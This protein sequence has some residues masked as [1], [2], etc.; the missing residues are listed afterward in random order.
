[1]PIPEKVTFKDFH[2]QRVERSFYLP[3][4]FDHLDPHDP[5]FLYTEIVESLD[6]S[7]IIE[8]HKRKGE[9]AYHPCMLFL[10]ILYGYTH[11]IFSSRK[12]AERCKKDLA[13]MYITG[14]LKPD[15][16]TISDFRKN[17]IGKIK[18]L[19]IQSVLIAKELQM[20]S[21]GHVS[22]D[23][24][25]FE[26][27][28]SKHKA[29]SYG[30]I[31]EK[32]ESLKKEIEALLTAAK[33]MDE[34]EDALHGEEKSGQEIPEELQ[35]KKN[36]LKKIR[37]AKKSLEK[38]EEAENPGKEIDDRKQISF[39]DNDAKIMG[40]GGKDFKYAYNAQVS[41][42]KDSQVIVGA[43]LT[44]K[45]NDMQEVKPALQEIYETTGQLPEKASLDAGYFSSDNL[46]E[47]EANKIDGY[48]A[49]G[50]GE[51][52]GEV[53]EVLP[54]GFTVAEDEE[55]LICRAGKT[56]VKCNEKGE[57]AVKSY[58]ASIEVCRNC[59]LSS[60]CRTSM[61]AKKVTLDKNKIKRE[62]MRIKLKTPEGKEVYAKRKHIVEP[63]F[64][65]IKN[66]M[67]FRR[68]QLRGF[69]KV[70]GE[71]YLICMAHNMKKVINQLMIA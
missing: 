41:V 69:E 56:L 53:K 63:V 9:N 50:K 58:K 23:G 62:E 16:R 36:R 3:S 19:F 49:T 8:T 29:M 38:R 22:L 2:S 33:E 44:Q 12:L 14:L 25:L 64:G 60:E 40:K 1:M 37:N 32:E 55:T 5:V 52:A 48:V 31:N 66:C 71:F 11:G 46:T 30:R 13:F 26:A 24:S 42:D 61:H 6:F 45:G 17:H 27:N 35:F 70:K 4:I 10:I 28:T 39:A 57:G 43:H 21:L 51:T 20:A 59:P 34:S 18:E 7:S 68:F 67:G 47:L 65:Q 15:F 54:A